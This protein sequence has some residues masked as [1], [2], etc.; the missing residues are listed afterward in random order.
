MK[1]SNLYIT[2]AIILLITLVFGCSK[3][4]VQE[5]IQTSGELRK[6]FADPPSEYRS[7]PLWDWNEQ[8]SKEGIG[9]Q[10]K[11]FK[12]AGIGGVF[13]HPRPGLITEYL[14]EDWFDLFDYTVQKGKELNMK[15]WIY[16]E[17]SYPAGFAGGH[18][19]A[20]MP[21]SY[22]NGTGLKM[23]I[24]QELKVVLSDTLAVVLKK[25]DTGFA[26]I[27]AVIDQEKGQKGTYYIFHKTY[28]EK[29][30]WYG[31]FSYV[32]LLVKGVTE[33]FIEVTMTKGYER[34]KADFGKTLM[35]SFTDEP[36]LEA[37]MSSGTLIR[38]TPDLWDAFQQRWG[39]DLKVNL[40]SLVEKTGN[41]K[42]VRHD[43]FELLLE[44]FV[45][46]WAKPWSKYCDENGLLWTGHYWEHGW[47]EPTHGF[48]ESAFYIWHHQPGIDMLGKTL[49]TDGLGE[50]FGND[51]GVREL[52][53]AANQAGRTRTLSETYGGGGWE[54]NFET[55]K[56][57]VD[58][59]CVL[60]VNFVNQHLSY[61]SL[62]GV[63]KFDYP[64]SFSYHEPWWEHYKLMGNYI[65]RISMAMSSGQ[66]INK[67]LVLQP[68]T[69]AW[70]YFSR[71]EMQSWWYVNPMIT[72]IR[73]KF[74]NFV[75]RM[76]QQ[77]LEYDLG[78]EYV[79]KELGSVVGNI[80]RVGKR[81][82]SLVVIPAEMEN[83]DQ[84]TFDMLR[85]YLKNG[86]KLLS[87][88]RNIAYLD[89][90][91]TLEVAELAA[92][93][94]DQWIFSD[95]LTDPA[96]LNL[97]THDEFT[98]NDQTLNGML[99][100][101]RR[102]LDD[103]QLLFMVNSH[104]AKG[105][106]AEV[107]MEGKY[108]SKLDLISG[109][110]FTYPSKVKNGKVS[111]QI[112]LDPVGSALF[113]VSTQKPAESELPIVSG[114]ETA[115]KNEGPVT[116]IRESDNILM[117][118]YLDLKTSKS[119]QKDIYFM[120]A[121]VCLFNENGVELGNPWQHKIQYK[122]DYLALDS[123]FKAE[124][125][126]EASYHFQIN[127]NL[128][129]VAL[130]SIRAVVERP[131][132]WTVS[133]NGTEVSKLEGSYWIDKGFPLFAVGPYLKQG[134][135][136]LTIKAR[137]MNILAEIMP[138][139]FLGD[140]LVNP[141]KQGFEIAGGEIT[142]L[143]SWSKLGLP[144]YP[145]KVNYSQTFN[146]EKITGASYKVRL[147]HWVGSIAEVWVNGKTAGLIAWHPNEADVTS[148]LNEGSN[149]ITVKITGSLKNTFGFYFYKMDRPV[150]SPEMWNH[151][152]EKTPGASEYILMDYGLFEPFDLIQV[153]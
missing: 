76:E 146:L 9:F 44:L 13:V 71:K 10:M 101:Q 132:L 12:K 32:D 57:L 90:T 22:K 66:Q 123:L 30:P 83:I 35:G 92:Q 106:S 11:E 34:N 46:R 51:R 86:G 43:Y 25:T 121:L 39:Y 41:W 29:S 70:M 53:S 59:Q 91:E 122:K 55:Q 8:I 130:R 103:G 23:E 136:T 72:E 139:Y 96:T 129:A 54:M 73:S 14:S 6:L 135:N 131:E 93:Y 82:Y 95:T 85:K 109:D 48:D 114:T 74:K 26:D 119:Y 94:P 112:N 145:H 65:G 28:P 77:H 98:I 21:D 61:Y 148:F 33:K 116:V 110:I 117:V 89:G 133:I 52:R 127:A 27:T 111:F 58:W 88:N 4:P 15:V 142:S 50:Q 150:I 17:N 2:T 138:V 75:Y 115:I 107:T 18:V 126:F 137:R 100:H 69:T 147:N 80:L 113:L 62:N 3:K 151:A 40:P 104:P 47:P 16:D 19:P 143:G 42:K 149:E 81:D 153:K 108:V 7:A 128:D 31:G 102:I 67:T 36:N 5:G 45:D 120:N 64:P 152:P 124:S 97:L 87:F 134:K 84:N 60:G 140:F 49:D 56:Q 24:Q 99:Y 68:N 37:A 144:F 141:A 63:R 125:G 1:K 20:Q 118:N 79:M 105:A 78:S 38:W